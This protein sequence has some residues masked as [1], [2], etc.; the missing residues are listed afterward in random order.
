MIIAA[1]LAFLNAKVIML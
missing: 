1:F